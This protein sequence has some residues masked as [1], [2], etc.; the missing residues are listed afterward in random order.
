MIVALRAVAPH[1]RA[2]A[3]HRINV[4]LHREGRRYM[5]L[6]V[7]NSGCG[8]R[9]VASFHHDELTVGS[10]LPIQP[11]VDSSQEVSG[12]KVNGTHS[13]KI[14]IIGVN[15]DFTAGFFQKKQM[16]TPPPAKVNPCST[17]MN[18]RENRRSLPHSSYPTVV[19]LT[20]IYS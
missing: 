16:L 1:N 14:E 10:I 7:I 8:V 11:A 12:V 2:V 13:G 5:R 6:V 20:C 4:R 9:R 18:T 15:S 19:G 17:R 3:S